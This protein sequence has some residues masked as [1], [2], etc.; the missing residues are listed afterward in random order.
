MR[1]GTNTMRNRA[2]KYT[3][4]LLFG[5]FLFLFLV[6]IGFPYE[7]IKE[8]IITSFED[9]FSYNLTIKDLQPLFP[10]GLGFKDIEITT[11]AED[12]KMPILQASSLV[13]KVKMLPLLMGNLNFEYAINTYGGIIKGIAEITRGTERRE[14][15][16][17]ADI[18]NVNLARYP[19]S[20]REM[21]FSP[22]GKINGNVKVVVEDFDTPNIKGDAILGIE[23]GKL[24]GINIKGTT[25]KEISYDGIDCAFELVQDGIDLKKLSLRGKDIE[26]NITGEILLREEIGESSLKLR[27]RFKPKKGLER[28]Y[29]LIFALFRDLKDKKGYFIL[30]VKGTLESPEISLPFSS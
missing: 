27:L 23:N 7:K 22:S 21:K 2:F 29:R 12:R 24:R 30:P 28:R 26:L 1:Q 14:A 6:Y 19:F 8:R 5:I 4:Y 11:N 3:A 17:V 9:R 10:S 13:V 15:S 25:I 20:R 16:L 18:H